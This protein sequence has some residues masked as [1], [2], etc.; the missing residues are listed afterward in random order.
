MKKGLLLTILMLCLFCLAGCS[1]EGKTKF[2]YWQGQVTS[3]MCVYLDE[4]TFYYKITGYPYLIMEYNVVNNQPVSALFGFSSY[5]RTTIYQPSEGVFIPV[6]PPPGPPELALGSYGYESEFTFYGDVIQI[7]SWQ[8][9]ETNDDFS[10]GLW[11]FW[12]NLGI[13]YNLEFSFNNV[14]MMGEFNNENPVWDSLGSQTTNSIVL[15]YIKTNN[16]Y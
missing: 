1:K 8:D 5:E 12:F 14:S 15:L 11:E 13:G 9:V 10:V 3:D 16:G 4:D 2:S 6:L 7:L